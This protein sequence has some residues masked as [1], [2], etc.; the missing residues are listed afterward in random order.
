MNL[1]TYITA[2]SF[3]QSLEK[4]VNADTFDI[5]AVN[6]MHIVP[7]E[8]YMYGL[9]LLRKAIEEYESE[10]DIPLAKSKRDVPFFREN[11]RMLVGPEYGLFIIPL[12][13]N[14]TM[15]K[16]ASN[17]GVIS[18]ILN[19]EKLTEY[20]L[21]ENIFLLK[22]KY[23]EKQTIDIFKSQL[24]KEYDKFFY[25]EEHSGFTADSKFFSMMCNACLEVRPPSF[26]WD[27]EWRMTLLK[28][29]EE[30]TYKYKEGMLYPYLT[31]SLPMDCITQ[32]SLLNKEE[33]PLLNG[34]FMNF[35][36]SKG[37]PPELYLEE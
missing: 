24:E 33:Q 22:C 23:D 28:S 16:L 18:I 7:S 4:C 29:P 2:E 34:S 10:H 35:M 1:Y 11:S 26:A 5:P 32:I 19:S 36:K 6:L 8:E 3:Y 13:E 15:P 25:D 27:K 14:P 12:Y 31:V 37:I 30:T 21:F 20:C 17:E 9:S